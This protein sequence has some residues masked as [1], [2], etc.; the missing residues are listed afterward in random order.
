MSS[1]REGIRRGAEGQYLL[2]QQI[3]GLPVRA[4]YTRRSVEEI[5]LPLLRKWTKLYR[6]KN[7][8]IVV[9]LAAPPATGKSTLASFLQEL[10][11]IT[12]DAEPVEAVG[13]DGFH[14][15]QADLK[16]HT[17][18]RNGEA[19]PMTAIKGA[20]VTFDLPGLTRRLQRLRTEELCPWPVY[21]R[22]LHDPQEGLLTVRGG[23]VLVEGN[24]LL[25]DEPGWR[26]LRGLCDDSVAIRA[27][28]GQLRERLVC[29]KMC[30][31]LSR[32]EAETFVD[33][34]DL[35]NVQLCCE[36]TMPANLQLRLTET[37]E[38][39]PA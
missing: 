24:Y 27:D 16:S 18:L 3:N 23:V 12:P 20:P 22:K 5:F 10:S 37:G 35:Q 29:R 33:R 13:M 36:R 30:S 1:D 6:E 2:E 19:L 21:D 38:Y 4:E 9:F 8:R 32:R 7:R 39:V 25:L 28:A 17:V 34:S 14:R 26:E 11:H 15:F 31:G